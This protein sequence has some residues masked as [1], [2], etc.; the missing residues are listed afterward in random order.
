MILNMN[1]LDSV[2]RFTVS[3]IILLL[4]AAQVITG[5]FSFLV[6]IPVLILVV[7]GFLGFCPMYRLFRI[8]SAMN[9]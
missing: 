5:T 4:Y 2:L 1:I 3:F 7:T 6:L 9:N 8:S